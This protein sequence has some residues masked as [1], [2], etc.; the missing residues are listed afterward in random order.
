MLFWLTVNNN[1]RLMMAGLCGDDETRQCLGSISPVTDSSKPEKLCSRI[2]FSSLMVP[3]LFNENKKSLTLIM[4]LRPANRRSSVRTDRL[5]VKGLPL[6]V[7]SLKYWSGSRLKSH[8]GMK[9]IWWINTI[10]SCSFLLGGAAASLKRDRWRSASA[11]TAAI[12]HRRSAFIWW[13]A[14]VVYMQALLPSH[15]LVCFST[16]N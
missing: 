7:N 10:Y 3:V 8:G 1:V 14:S 4:K 13:M 6:L 12:Q 11:A 15:W 9:I 2:I 5:V 16:P